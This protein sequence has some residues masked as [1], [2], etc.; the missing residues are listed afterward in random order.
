MLSAAINLTDLYLE[1]ETAWLDAMSERIQAGAWDELDYVHLQEYLADMAKPDRRE[2]ESRLVV[3]LTHLLKW[4][5]QPDR[6]SR[7]WVLSIIVQRQELVRDAGK[8]VLR[9]HAEAVLHDAYADAVVR[10]TAETGLAAAAFPGQCPFT[11][12]ELL[13][14]EPVL[15]H[16]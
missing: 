3:L 6:R 5:F 16:E 13:A 8:G 9:N 4:N 2:V 11:L 7:S 15:D 12:E 14:F 10:A 1:D